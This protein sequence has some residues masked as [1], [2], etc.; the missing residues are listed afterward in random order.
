MV[1]PIDEYESL[2]HL[3]QVLPPVGASIRQR[4]AMYIGSSDARGLEQLLFE[5]LGNALDLHLRGQ[6]KRIAIE[7][8]DHGGLTVTDDGPGF[9]PGL[10]ESAFF[11]LHLEP[12]LDGHHP[13]VHVT[14]FLH[15][16]GLVAVNFLS[17]EFHL[18]T[19]FEGHRFSAQMRAGDVVQPWT[20]HGPSTARGTR[21]HF[22]PD[23]AVFHEHRLDVQAL[24][25]RLQ[26]LAWLN[27]QLSLSFNGERFENFRGLWGFCE[28]LAGPQ[29][30]KPSA[31]RVS[32]QQND[33]EVQL[34]LA[35]SASKAGPQVRSFVN[36]SPTEGG[37]HVRGA[38]SALQQV[39]P[40]V[41]ISKL[42]MGLT[43]VVHV[44]L[45]HPRFQG[46]VKALLQVD[47][48]QAAVERLL[49]Q[50]LERRG[51][52]WKPFLKTK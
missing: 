20:D 6:A 50:A 46:P 40:F 14:P 52:F 24:R 23:I 15:Q 10:F 12:T 36:Y 47:E 11:R 38:L 29:L 44:M 19:H 31:L 1:S 28:Q 51:F 4:P 7:Y 16:V 21:M 33:I 5:V 13:H 27:E 17:S 49:S 35:Y 32:G 41:E 45:L 37:S 18:E 25:H 26:S 8:D 48:A 22:V 3:I 39:A 30:V 34:A 2:A 9:P 43:L 42:Q